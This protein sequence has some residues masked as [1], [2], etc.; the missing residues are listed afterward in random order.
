MYRLQLEVVQT[1]QMRTTTAW[2][3]LS[4]NIQSREGT[5]ASTIGLGFGQWRNQI[6]YQNAPPETYMSLSF[7]IPT[8]PPSPVPYPSHDLDMKRTRTPVESVMPSCV[9]GQCMVICNIRIYGEN[10]TLTNGAASV[11]I[12]KRTHLAVGFDENQIVRMQ[13]HSWRMQVPQ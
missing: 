5:F 10:Y 12:I 6:Y 7:R 13:R 2:Q 8:S 3:P 11:R 9:M 4:V 1:V